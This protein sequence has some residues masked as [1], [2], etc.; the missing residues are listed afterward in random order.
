[1]GV[2]VKDI[3]EALG[4]SPATVSLAI[5]NRPG[6]NAETRDRVLEAVRTLGYEKVSARG[7]AY[8]MHTI[9]FVIFKQRATAGLDTSF[10]SEMMEGVERQADLAGAN[11][12]ITYINAEENIPQKL[13]S[14]A[15]AGSRGVIL[16]ATELTPPHIQDF[17][18]MR[19]PMVV[20]D[21]YFEGFPLDC[22][23]INNAQGAYLATTY[24]AEQG[25]SRI[26]YLTSKVRTVNFSERH[27]GFRKAFRKIGAAR[28]P[29]TFQLTPSI[30]GA[31]EDMKIFLQ[32][33]PELPTAFFADNDILAAG[34]MR[35]F[36]EMGFRVPED[37]SIVGFDDIPLCTLLDPPLTTVSVP[38]KRLGSLAVERLY[39]KIEKNAP[40][41]I[42]IEVG[43]SLVERGTV[44]RIGHG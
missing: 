12:M 13:A 24:L 28:L 11:L 17:L 43:T 38:K 5:N 18:S 26:G 2:K 37:V 35:A 9:H 14:L 19:I 7:P 22:V 31:C 41:F 40:E 10:F 16:L 29:Y 23:T 44:R 8:S 32:K 20:L 27:E 3:A 30:E 6:V 1:M 34:A 33:G 15:T 42:K 25:H 21:A 39:Q 36:K 4:L